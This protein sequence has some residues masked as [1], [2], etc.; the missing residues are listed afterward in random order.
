MINIPVFILLILGHYMTGWGVLRAIGLRKFHFSIQYTLLSV[1]VGL[2]LYCLL[3]PILEMLSVEITN[4]S[5]CAIMLIVSAVPAFFWIWSFKETSIAQAA[6]SYLR[7]IRLYDI[8]FLFVLFYLMYVG[9]YKCV[10]FAPLPRDLTSG[11][12]AIAEYTLR[13]HHMANS[14]FT[15]DLSTTDNH[16]KPPFLCG[17]QIIYK[18]FVQPFGQVWLTVLTT[19]F[20]LLFYV[21]MRKMVHP[22]FAGIAAL[23][24]LAN[25]ELYGYIIFPLF[26]FPNMAYLFIAFYYLYRYLRDADRKNLLLCSLGLGMA[27]LARP[28]TLLLVG[29]VC[30][31]Y[32]SWQAIRARKLIVLPA[33]TTCLI[34][35]VVPLAIDLFTMK[36]FVQHFLPASLDITQ[37]INPD[38]TN[39]S[40]FIDRWSMLIN[41]LMFSPADVPGV[42][43]T[44]V[45]YS[46]TFNFMLVFIVLEIATII[47]TRKF[48]FNASTWFLFMVLVFILLGLIHYLL[49]WTEFTNAKRAL[50]KLI[51]LIFAFGVNTRAVQFVSEKIKQWESR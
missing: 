30:I 3:P 46:E 19:S 17:L 4:T 15:V 49:L 22:I 47:I 24:V 11:A 32:Y 34:L 38:L 51:P 50:F 9:L 25:P 18:S 10:Y 21:L 31:F 37:K 8:A 33:L 13:E 2:G 1:M 35:I 26:D 27:T 39:F 16:Q 36:L 45:W 12:E 42:T 20:Y 14:Y 6:R 23:L 29:L 5:L 43:P 41:K 28:E 40:P 7:A 44:H 48:D